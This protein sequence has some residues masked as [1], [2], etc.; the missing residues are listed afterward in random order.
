MLF[1]LWLVNSS[2]YI[3][4]EVVTLSR[5]PM[6]LRS[7]CLEHFGNFEPLQE[8]LMLLPCL[9][10]SQMTEWIILVLASRDCIWLHLALLLL[11]GLQVVLVDIEG[12][13]RVIR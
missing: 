11:W 8:L 5:S 9:V 13:S 12:I 1:L 4:V 10:L 6:R 2:I 7:A 3:E